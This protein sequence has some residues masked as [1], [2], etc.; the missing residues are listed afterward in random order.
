MRE[1]KLISVDNNLTAGNKE[2][3]KAVLFKQE[4]N[5]VQ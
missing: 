1:F 2:F 3:V 4:I 5:H